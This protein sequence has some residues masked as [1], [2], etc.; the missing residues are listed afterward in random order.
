MSFDFDQFIEF[1]DDVFA[2]SENSSELHFRVAIG[3][4]YYGVF[5]MACRAAN[6]DPKQRNNSHQRLQDI[7]RSGSKPKPKIG[8]N[9]ASLHALRCKADYHD[10]PA[11]GYQDANSAKRYARRISSDIKTL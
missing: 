3:R 10:D 8:N 5:H 7:Y 6:F 2:A 1:A 9:L 4:W 11:I